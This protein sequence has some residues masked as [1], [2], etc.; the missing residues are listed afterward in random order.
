MKAC[1]QYTNALKTIMKA[2]KGLHVLLAKVK[3]RFT[4]KVTEYMP[5]N[6]HANFYRYIQR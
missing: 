6:E 2:T 3:S 5:W 4:P 1:R